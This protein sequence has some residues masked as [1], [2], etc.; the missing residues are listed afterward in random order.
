MVMTMMMKI[1]VVTVVVA[2]GYKGLIMMNCW[3][4]RLQPLV[5]MITT[6]MISTMIVMVMLIILLI[7]HHHQCISPRVNLGGRFIGVCNDF[8]KR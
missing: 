2:F 5:L 4:D 7:L 3:S 8:G 1:M 6:V